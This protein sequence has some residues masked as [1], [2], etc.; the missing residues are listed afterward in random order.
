SWA[1]YKAQE[2]LVQSCRSAGVELTLFH[3]R[4]GSVGRG[5]GPTYLAIQSQPPGSV[6]LRLRV[7]EQGEM[8]QAKFGL[9]GLARRTLEV[10]ITATPDA[11]LAPPA[12]PQPQ[13]RARMDQLAETA[14]TAYRT[15]VY[16]TPGFVE[17][18]QTATPVGE[19][20]DLTIASRPARRRTE[21]GIETL[22]AIPWVF[23][24]TQTR[25]L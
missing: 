16:G 2:S 19:L 25:L 13:W 22:R 24:W 6:D 7:T 20:G 23:A 12:P 21:G 18:F 11:S 8:G 5:G 10:Y 1:L 15:V 9:P 14:R 3:G 4:G 17:Y